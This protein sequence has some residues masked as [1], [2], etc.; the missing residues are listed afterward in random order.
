[1]RRGR[2]WRIR[3]LVSLEAF[4]LLLFLVGDGE[5][6]GADDWCDRGRE[7]AVQRFQFSE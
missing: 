5:K 3:T 1:M 7:C 6:I 2:R 4:C